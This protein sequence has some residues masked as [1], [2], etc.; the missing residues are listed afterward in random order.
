MTGIPSGEN[1][2]TY[3]NLSFSTGHP[4]GSHDDHLEAGIKPVKQENTDNHVI[5][6]KGLSP[7]EKQAEISK[8]KFQER[9]LASDRQITV[10]SDIGKTQELIDQTAARPS[11]ASGEFGR[12]VD[13]CKI[14]KS[15][16][17]AALVKKT[18]KTPFEENKKEYAS[19]EKSVKQI[20]IKI[21]TIDKSIAVD[22]K[23]LQSHVIIH[24]NHIIQLNPDDPNHAKYFNKDNKEIGF[25]I[26]DDIY[27]HS[28]MKKKLEENPNLQ[29]R[30]KNKP[31]D[32][33]KIKKL[34]NDKYQ[35]L[36][37]QANKSFNRYQNLI[38][39]KQALAEEKATLIKKQKLIEYGMQQQLLLIQKTNNK[40]ENF[41][42]IESINITPQ[43]IQLILTLSSR[44]ILQNQKTSD[45]RIQKIIE[46]K[47]KE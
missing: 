25:I 38:S 8:I 36:S 29:L 31:L 10:L 18:M 12:L 39:Q 26:D 22:K 11:D 47:I 45:L 33:R 37:E 23:F 16:F 1:S 7:E 4:K 20:D 41:S 14:D 3:Q 6:A 2:N 5:S 28:E 17:D 35:K 46:E 43:I 30:Y 21:D 9:T 32:A 34:S 27:F 19:I 44:R 15:P 42:D 13:Q 24:E 40:S